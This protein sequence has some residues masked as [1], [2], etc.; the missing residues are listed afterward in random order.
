M[1]K[2]RWAFFAFTRSNTTDVPTCTGV[3]DNT[4]NCAGAFAATSAAAEDCVETAVGGN[5]VAA[6][7]AACDAVTLG[8]A[9][10][11]ADCADAT[12]D[13]ASGTA[14]G[15]LQHP[16]GVSTGSACTY[17]APVP[18]PIPTNPHRNLIS[19][20]VSEDLRVDHPIIIVA[21]HKRQQLPRGVRL[22]GPHLEHIR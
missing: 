8:G 15:C 10:S 6:D 11:H 17:T 14:A 3:G 5:I 7:T 1:T 21:G 20:D 19:R 22:R 9:T 18:P 4:P 2:D 12:L 16:F 13:C